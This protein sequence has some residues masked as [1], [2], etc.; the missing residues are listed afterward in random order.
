MEQVRN[1]RDRIKFQYEYAQT[2]LF[3][4]YVHSDSQSSKFP[5]D[6]KAIPLFSA[7]ELAP[8]YHDGANGA[9][10][11][12][13]HY[14]RACKSELTDASFSNSFHTL[15]LLFCSLP[16]LIGKLRHPS[17]GRLYTCR[18]CC[19]QEREMPM[20][21]QDAPLDRYSVTEVL[22]M[23]CG[24]LQPSGVR[25][26]NEKCESNGKP[27]AKYNCRICNLYDDGPSKNIYHCPFCNVCRQGLGLGIDYRHCMRC[28]A[29]VSLADDEHHCIPQRLQG[30]CPI[31][32]ESMF[33][34]TEPLRGLK[35]GHVMHLSC[36]GMYVRG[37]NFTCP[38]CKKSM[39][40]MTEYF[41][42]LDAAVRMQPMPTAYMATMS[43]IY[44]QDC[45]N[46]GQVQY[47]FVGCKCS[48][49]GSYNTREVGRVQDM[50]QAVS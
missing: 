44:C 41:A 4:C 45:G 9:V 36:F 42:M 10:L 13:P 50:N 21:D 46:T 11:G 38:L 15:I 25:C 20:K 5:S 47:H 32:N 30:S 24:A 33:E 6:D 39:E 37:Q 31:C 35:C 17:S 29:C 7:A 16:V 18:L 14:A 40:D 23:R 22:C 3:G 27:F 8:T 1:D 19:A 34:S 43:N 12:C 2:N 48:H 28:N 26:V 49:C